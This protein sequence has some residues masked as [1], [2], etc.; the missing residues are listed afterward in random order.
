MRFGRF[1]LDDAEGAILA[2]GARLPGG[3]LKKGRVLTADDVSTLRSAGLEAVTAARLEP[4]DVGE[5]EA[6]LALARAALGPGVCLGAAATGRCNLFATSRGL[7]VVERE[8]L[9]RCNLAHEGITIATVTPYQLVEPRDVVAT[10]KIVPLAVERTALDACIAAAS[11]PAPLVRVA[12]L[13]RKAAGLIQTRLPGTKESV[14]D[15]TADTTRMRLS[16]LGSTL[17][18]E[19]RCTHDEAEVA[20]A[21]GALTAQGV[22]IILILGASATVDRRDVVPAAIVEAGGEVDHFGMP[23]DPGNLTLLAHVGE[24]PVVGLPG[25]ARSPTTHGF[26]WLLRRLLADI[27]VAAKDIMLMGAGGLL[28]DIRLR[29]LPRAKASRIAPVLAAKQSRRIAAVVLAAGQSR[30]MGT[31]NKLLSEIDGVPMVARVVAAAA[32]SK[33]RAVI[34]VTGHDAAKVRAALAGHD[35]TFAH[36][37]DFAEGLSTSLRVGLAALPGDVEGGDAEGA[38]VCLGDMP[39][40]SAALIDRLIA[41][42]DPGAGRAI[43]VPTHLGKRGNP[44]LWARRFFPEIA[45][46][47]GDVGARHLIGEHDDMVHEVESADGGVLVDVDTPDA[48][49]AL[50]RPPKAAP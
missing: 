44:V 11:D 42:F 35:V 16:A 5:D 15:K 43:C 29:P 21:I 36:N 9:D 39:R 48:L 28:K 8:R 38:V 40:V 24:A 26:D 45:A 30:R 46:V 37:P 20:S 49:T 6:A 50:S 7:A 12:E 23:V 34:V 19:I 4:G 25:S 22:D 13:V 14:L 1:P 41:A 47:S 32:A 17:I 10:V 33:T 18:R 27:P 31:I 3:A 2:H